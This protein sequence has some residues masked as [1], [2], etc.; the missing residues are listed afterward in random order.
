MPQ[1]DGCVY[2]YRDAALG[3]DG[4]VAVTHA[5][6]GYRSQLRTVYLADMWGTIP[7]EAFPALLDAISDRHRQTADLLAIRCVR[8][9]YEQQALAAGCVRRDFD[10][11]IGW[12]VDSG[13]VLGREPVLIPPAAT[14]LV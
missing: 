10:R 1:V 8:E 5:R 2:R 9:P 4:F 7:P 3:A 13:G 12:L 6:R 14:E 11:P